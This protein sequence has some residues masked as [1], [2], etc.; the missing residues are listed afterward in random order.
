MRWTL[1]AV[2]LSTGCVVGGGDQGWTFERP[3]SVVVQVGSGSIDV[4]SSPDDQLRAWWEGGGFGDNASP[5]VYE[6]GGVVWID[7]NGGV[8]GGGE[9]RVEVPAGTSMDLEVARG[10]IHTALT[11]QASIEACVAAGEVSLGV[12]PGPYVLDL[13]IGLGHLE[14]ELWHDPTSPYRLSACTAVGDLHVYIYEG[15]SG[16]PFDPF[17]D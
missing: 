5:D 13:A 9:V 12:A 4:V 17:A 6:E 2:I 8:L 15:D 11:E 16:A 1:W 7:A 10:E 14:S 3:T